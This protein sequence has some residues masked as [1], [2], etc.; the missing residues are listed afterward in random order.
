MNASEETATVAATSEP[1]TAPQPTTA[2]PSGPETA[3]G[4][5]DAAEDATTPPVE[6]VTEL[7]ASSVWRRGAQ[8]LTEVA[9][10]VLLGMAAVVAYS[11]WN[12]GPVDAA[13]LLAV[14]V[15][16]AVLA[17]L[18]CRP[19]WPRE[20]L[21]LD[22]SGIVGKAAWARIVR[23]EVRWGWHDGRVVRLVL[24]D[25]TRVPVGLTGTLF[26]PDKRFA[27]SLRRLIE[28]ARH[29]NPAITV[30][31]SG[32][33][34]LLAGIVLAQL[35]TMAGINLWQRGLTGPWEPVAS[36][37]V[38]ACAALTSDGGRRWPGRV[39]WQND[40]TPGRDLTYCTWLFTAPDGGWTSFDHARVEITT[41]DGRPTRS[42]VPVAA[43]RYR[44]DRE[45]MVAPVPLTGVGDEASMSTHWDHVQVVARRANVTLTV[46]LFHIGQIPP[47]QE[48]AAFIAAETLHGIGQGLDV[49]PSPGLIGRGW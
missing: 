36:G 2:D 38:P 32:F 41:H 16:V 3:R 26:W 1:R 6:P 49:D 13:R 20:R 44:Y 37:P 34:L 43:N 31:H 9:Y 18:V 17:V 15:P 5:A 24:D 40:N 10:T 28:V 4:E 33:P 35:V 23:V 7:P 25:W 39:L 11:D 45:A 27:A 46:R 42:A 29:H 12:Y 47:A 8:W 19:G 21:V 48:A 22:R 30:R 14:L